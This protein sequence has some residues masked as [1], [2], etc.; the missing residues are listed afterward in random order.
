LEIQTESYVSTL[1][2]LRNAHTDGARDAP[3]PEKQVATT[4]KMTAHISTSQNN[5]AAGI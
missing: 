4:T 2:I 1:N 5:K 3:H